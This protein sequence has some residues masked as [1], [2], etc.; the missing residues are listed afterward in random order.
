MARSPTGVPIPPSPPSSASSSTRGSQ[1]RTPAEDPMYTGLWC[2]GPTI[3]SASCGLSFRDDSMAA[4]SIWSGSSCARRS[5]LP[6]SSTSSATSLRVGCAR[7]GGSGQPRDAGPVR[8]RSARLPAPGPHRRSRALRARTGCRL[9]AVVNFDLPRST[10]DHIHRIGRTGRA[11]ESG[12]AVSFID[13]DTAP[14][15]VLKLIGPMMQRRH[16]IVHRADRN[17]QIGRGHHQAQSLSAPTLRTWID[18][19]QRLGGQILEFYK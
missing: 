18:A 7:S 13:H 3:S 2:P 15:F 8:R 14:R 4:R 19:T 1:R 5:S 10:R 6:P 16:W 11:G 12:V 9:G 17:H